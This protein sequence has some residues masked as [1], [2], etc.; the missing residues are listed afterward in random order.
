MWT[1]ILWN[2]GHPLSVWVSTFQMMWVSNVQ[3][4]VGVGVGIGVGFW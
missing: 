2:P 4:G 3:I 1:P